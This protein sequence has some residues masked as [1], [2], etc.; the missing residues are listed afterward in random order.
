MARPTRFFALIALCFAALA[1]AVSCA[2]NPVSGKRQLALLSEADEIRLGRENDAEIRKKFGVYPDARLQAYIQQIGDRLAARSHRPH[3]KYTFTVLDSPDVNA[4]ALPGGYIYI[5]RGILAHLNSEAEVAAVLGH[6]I[7]HVTA[8]HSVQQYSAAVAANIGF[9]LGS[10]LVPEMAQRGAQSLFNVLGNALLSGYGRDH[11]LEADRL[12]AEYLARTDYNPQAML[13]VLTLL[14]NQ[15]VFEK[16]LAAKEHRAPRVYHGV[17]ASHPSADQ[18]L[19]EVVGL[20]QKYRT[21]QNGRVERDS[22]LRRLDGLVYGDS[23]AQGIRRGNSFYHHGLDFAVRF[24]TGWQLDNSPEMLLARTP[25]TDALVQMQA[26][27]RGNARTPQEYLVVQ[28]RLHDLRNTAAFRVD[29]LPA[30]RGVTRMQTPFGTR[31]AQV[32]VVF[33]GNQAFRFLGAARRDDAVFHQRFLETVQ[34]LHRMTASERTL[35]RA[36]RLEVRP[37]RSGENFSLW[38]RATPVPHEPEAVLRLL[39]GVY[40]QGEPSTGDLVKLIH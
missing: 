26:A 28:M 7:G 38:A 1:A 34:S 33:L 16:R 9:T 4:F 27:P 22:Y 39:N 11:E 14:K 37:R 31:D 3:L 19:Q 13:G 12:G 15:E 18:R 6:E 32:A 8:R 29:D 30:Y 23:E 5:T 36:L 20:A 10:I 25:D 21:A 17:F 35:A 24:P 2:V 40:P